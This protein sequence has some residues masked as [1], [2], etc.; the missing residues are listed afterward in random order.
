MGRAVP[1]L[2]AAVPRPAP[3]A[4]RAQRR[5]RPAPQ[6]RAQR[7]R[8]RSPLMLPLLCA[9][10]CGLGDRVVGPPPAAAAAA[11]AAGGPP[12][13]LGA[14]AAFPEPRAPSLA[15]PRRPG[16]GAAPGLSGDSARVSRGL[17]GGPTAAPSSPPSAKPSAAPS[18]APSRAPRAAGTP[19]AAPAPAP[20]GQPSPTSSPNNPTAPS[21]T[22]SAGAAPSVPPST[23]PSAAPSTAPAQPSAAPSSSPSTAPS[24]APSL[25]PSAQPSAP[26]SPGAPPSEPPSA[27]AAPSAA[28][29]AAAAPSQPPSAAP[30]T[31]P[32]AGRT[33]APS[34]APTAAPRPGP[35]DP[36]DPPACAS[37]PCGAG[38]WCTE[39]GPVSMRCTCE[40]PWVGQ[41]VGGRSNCTLY[42][43]PFVRL[44]LAVKFRAAWVPTGEWVQRLRET[45]LLVY[46]S[47][48]ITR[49]YRPNVNISY[50]CPLVKDRKPTAD[51]DAGRQ[52]FSPMLSGLVPAPARHPQALAGSEI[53]VANLTERQQGVFAELEIIEASPEFAVN[54]AA[55]L[56]KDLVKAAANNT[57]GTSL[58]RDPRNP[59]RYSPLLLIAPLQF[60]GSDGPGALWTDTSAF[61]V[62]EY[63]ID[64]IGD[65]Q[66]GEPVAAPIDSGSSAAGPIVTATGACAMVT[67]AFALLFAHRRQQKNKVSVSQFVKALDPG[68]QDLELELTV[69]AAS[70]GTVND[71][72]SHSGLGTPGRASSP[73]VLP[74]RSGTPPLVGLSGAVPPPQ[75][76]HLSGPAR[77]RGRA[78]L[79]TQSQLTS[80]PPGSSR[81]S[82]R[83]RPSM[84]AE[85]LRC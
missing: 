48:G 8:C 9:S 44:Y 76:L 27:A 54:A 81:T 40:L 34:P 30:V 47:F 15:R 62:A 77:G 68:D 20:S 37:D 64:L 16:T 63:R 79:R 74:G 33:P 61:H 46:R 66:E 21:A 84:A 7:P 3:A 52:C 25:P 83:G 67:L 14:D 28:P 24:A 51:S 80:P 42:T 13:G 10:C 45:V 22:P 65:W 31:T 1:A 43:G 5:G 82:S 70:D 32:T 60:A 18:A 12:A 38:Q 2:S 73:L 72:S 17:A 41:A 53:E 57:N 85:T 56:Q 26:P 75:R 71:Y 35:T 58:V 59:L 4:A 6:H 49:G 39:A 36:P 11:A 55:A 78:Q 69:P 29:S 19:T 50:L 23:L